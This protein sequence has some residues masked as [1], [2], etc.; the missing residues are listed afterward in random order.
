MKITSLIVL[1]WRNNSK[2][3]FGLK[4][5]DCLEVILNISAFL[6][7]SLCTCESHTSKKGVTS[8]EISTTVRAKH[9]T[10]SLSRR[11]HYE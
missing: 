10:S 6:I 1:M 7:L 3:E 9:M 4:Q 11:L 2:G 5:D 8:F